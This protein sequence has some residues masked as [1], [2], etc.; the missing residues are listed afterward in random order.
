MGGYIE[1]YVKGVL[2]C[3]L[4]WSSSGQGQLAGFCECGD[5]VSGSI[6]CGEFLD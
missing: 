3:G 1:M 4:N 2:D 5:E 6:K